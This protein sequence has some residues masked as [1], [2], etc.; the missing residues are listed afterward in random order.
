MNILLPLTIEQHVDGSYFSVDICL[1]N[2]RPMAGVSGVVLVP[3]MWVLIN[4][5]EHLAGRKSA[6][7]L[8]CDNRP[9]VAHVRWV[10]ITAYCTM[11]VCALGLAVNVWF[12]GD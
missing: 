12:M 4:L 5:Y 6:Y 10:W 1:L 9:R 3:A 11:I 2:L 8:F 7:R